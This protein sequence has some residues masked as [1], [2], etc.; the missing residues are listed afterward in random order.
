MSVSMTFHDFKTKQNKKVRRNYKTE[1]GEEGKVWT[2]TA[3]TVFTNNL[4]LCLMLFYN[5]PLFKVFY[6]MWK[7]CTTDLLCTGQGSGLPRSGKNLFFKVRE[8]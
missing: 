3:R 5:F 1:L 7:A 8:K 4:V 2:L 6:K